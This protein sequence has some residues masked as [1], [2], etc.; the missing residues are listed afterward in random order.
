[1]KDK[2]LGHRFVINIYFSTIKTEPFLKICSKSFGNGVS[3]LCVANARGRNS[4]T[5]Y[6][7]PMRLRKAGKQNQVL[8]LM[9]VAFT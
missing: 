9:K 1:L 3:S 2:N 6:I 4:V 8:N 5:Q 7:N